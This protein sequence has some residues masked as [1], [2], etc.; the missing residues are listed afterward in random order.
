MNSSL[1]MGPTDRSPCLFNGFGGWSIASGVLWTNRGI[2]GRPTLLRTGSRVHDL[3]Q[4]ARDP[5]ARGRNDSE[6]LPIAP[7]GGFPPMPGNRLRPLLELKTGRTPFVARH[8]LCSLRQ[9][10][11]RATSPLSSDDACRSTRS[12]AWPSR[13]GDWAIRRRDPRSTLEQAE[14]LGTAP[15]DPAGVRFLVSH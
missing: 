13:K 11:W 3:P 6:N 5:S 4:Q 1:V 10:I 8:K 7:Q 12:N 9:S 15:G 2:F 14:R